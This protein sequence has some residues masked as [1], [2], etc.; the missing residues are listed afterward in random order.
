M[1]LSALFSFRGDGNRINDDHWEALPLHHIRSFTQK[2][3]LVGSGDADGLK[4][5]LIFRGLSIIL[6]ASVDSR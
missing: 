1:N 6:T 5:Y 2:F 4:G 3:P